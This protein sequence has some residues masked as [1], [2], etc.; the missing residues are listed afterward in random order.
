MGNS[1]KKAFQGVLDKVLGRIEGWRAKTLSQ[2]SRL[3]LIKLV[4]AALPCYAMS[5]FLL[6]NSLCNALDWIFNNF[7]WGF[8]PKRAK[9]LLLKAWDSLCLPKSLGGLGLR[10]MRDVYLALISKLGWKLHTR[11]TT[12]WTAQLQGKYLKTC[13]FLSPTSLSFSSSWLWKGNLKSK[14]LI[15]K[16]AYNR[17]HSFSSLPIWSSPWIPTNLAFTHSSSVLLRLPLPDLLVLDLFCYD[18]STSSFSWNFSL[19]NSLFDSANVREILKTS[20]SSLFLLISIYGPPPQMAHSLQ[21][22]LTSSSATKELL[23]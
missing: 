12:L 7:W 18:P 8:H 9:N 2:A 14:H 20:F 17:I 13:S 15:S 3:V 1:R 22:L 21:I 6:P 4:A 5:S 19:L 11:T 10:R 23:L 16:G